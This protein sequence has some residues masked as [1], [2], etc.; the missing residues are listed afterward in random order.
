MSSN[1][2][3]A[4]I[5]TVV[6]GDGAVGKTSLL[7]T[8]GENVFP[9]EHVPT[10]FDNYLTSVDVDGR[11]VNLAMWD[12]AGQ[13]EY[14]RLRPL[15]YPGAHVFLICFSVDNPA[16]YHNVKTKWAVEVRH[17]APNVPIILVATKRD[18]RYDENTINELKKRGE[19]PVDTDLGE[20][21]RADIGAERYVEC[22]AKTQFG[23]KNVFDT[24]I[25]TVLKP[26]KKP[27]KPCN[28]L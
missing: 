1:N 16:S 17:H 20:Q 9:E 26:K 12:T 2:N 18:L 14:D 25:N 23:V 7:W 6:I 13:E 11:T 24:A 28:I 15:S 4:H 3:A 27:S 10:V 8:F 21:L 5:K 19:A 22:S